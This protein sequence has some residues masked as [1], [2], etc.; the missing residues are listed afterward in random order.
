MCVDEFGEYG[1]GLY[2]IVSYVMCCGGV[3]IFEDNDFCG[4]LFLIYIS[5]VKF[6]DSFI[7]FIDC[8]GWNVV[9]RDVCGIYSLY[10][11][12]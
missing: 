5:K 6:N 4:I 3:I 11:W 9:G 10:F 1:I 2:L 12:I 7:N 8:W